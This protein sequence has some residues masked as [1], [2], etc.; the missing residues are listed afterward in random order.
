M[1]LAES[2]VQI[3]E[4]HARREG[5]ERV[6]A[7]WLQIGELA[8]VELDALRFCFDAATRGGPAEGARLEILAS[9]GQAWCLRCSDVVRIPERTAPCPR[10]GS[11]QLQVTGGTEMKV[12]ELEVV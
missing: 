6:R 11:F 9:P 10:C 5:C 12:R 8:G 4:D 2:I 3:V 7:V 1:S